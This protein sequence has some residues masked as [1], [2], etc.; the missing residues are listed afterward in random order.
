MLE[1]YNIDKHLLGNALRPF[2]FVIRFDKPVSRDR[3]LMD[4]PDTILITPETFILK[5]SK[6]ER[7]STLYEVWWTDYSLWNIV[8]KD[9]EATAGSIL[10]LFNNVYHLGSSRIYQNDKASNT[11]QQREERD[12][13][14][15][16]HFS[17]YIQLSSCCLFCF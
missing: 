3:G 12:K 15:T 1:C 10:W 17:R 9:S 6:A 14:L 16:I 7:I 2:C 13:M 11:K 4:G 5:G 8:Q